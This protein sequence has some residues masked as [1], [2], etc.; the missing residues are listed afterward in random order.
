M[1]VDKAVATFPEGD[2]LIEGKKILA[3]GAAIDATGHVV[4]PGFI[5][6]PLHQFKTALRSLPADANLVNDGRAE[7]AATYHEWML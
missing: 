3:V 2:V 6:T 5:D 7:G 4:M 1:S